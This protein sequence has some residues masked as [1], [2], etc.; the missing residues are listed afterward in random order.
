MDGDQCACSHANVTIKTILVKWFE[1]FFDTNVF[2]FIVV[3]IYLIAFHQKSCN[4]AK[5]TMKP[6]RV[7]RNKI[8]KK[9]STHKTLKAREGTTSVKD[10]DPTWGD[11]LQQEA[12]EVKH[13]VTARPEHHHK[14]KSGNAGNEVHDHAGFF[15][16]AEAAVKAEHEKVAKIKKDRRDNVMR[17]A[18]EDKD[19]E[20]LKELWSDYA[21]SK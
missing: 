13:A 11:K 20:K 18:I 16:P 4:D 8:V 12:Q 2:S 10:W 5:I 17:D 21:G 19:T 14:S 7:K 3:F 6:I 15:S 9:G 1:L